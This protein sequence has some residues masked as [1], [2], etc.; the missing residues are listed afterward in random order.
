MTSSSRK[1]VLQNLT[2][3]YLPISLPFILALWIMIF[4]QTYMHF[5]KMEK[6][7]KIQLSAGSATLLS[8]ILWLITYIAFYFTVEVF[9]K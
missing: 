8:A 5:P 4:L 6:S 1:M 9:I 2:L 7:K 3:I